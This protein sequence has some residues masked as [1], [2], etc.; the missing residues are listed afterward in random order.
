MENIVIS[1]KIHNISVLMKS[2][3]RLTIFGRMMFYGAYIIKNVNSVFQWHSTDRDLFLFFRA[4]QSIV[5]Y[6]KLKHISNCKTLTS[7]CS[8]AAPSTDLTKKR[9]GGEEITGNGCYRRTMF[10]ICSWSDFGFHCLGFD[11]KFQNF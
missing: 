11:G 8:L 3:A 5:G 4:Y 2:W 9:L 6:Y 10:T 1:V 7:R